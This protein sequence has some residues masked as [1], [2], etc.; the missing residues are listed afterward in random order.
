MPPSPAL[1]LTRQ[2][3][4]IQSLRQPACYAHPVG[5]VELIETHISFVLL[6]GDYVYKIKKEVNFGFLD[7]SSL[8]KRKQ[9]CEEELRLNRRQA[10]DLYLDV[11]AITGTPEHPVLG[12]HGAAFE[13][14]VKMRRFPQCALLDQR[15]ESG[16]LRAEHIDLLATT[17]VDFHQAVNQAE[18]SSAF[19]GLDQ[20]ASYTLENCR[21]IAPL[22][23]NDSDKERLAFYSDWVQR[24]H[25][26]HSALFLSRKQSGFIRECHGD[27]H[28][29]NIT[30]D[31][32][33]IHFFDCIEF[34]PAL[35]WI[36]VISELAFLAM[37]LEAAGQGHYSHRLINRY[38]ELT[39]D[40]T[41]VPLLRYY[42]AYRAMVRA[43]VAMLRLPQAS[44]EKER[45]T[46]TRSCSDYLHLAW[47][48][49]AEYS[50]ALIITHGLSG[51]GKSTHTTTLVEIIGAIRLR[52][53]VERKRL[54]GVAAAQSRQ[55]EV[56]TGI[57]SPDITRTLYARLQA[58]AD[59]ILTA[60]FP[61]IIDATCLKRWQRD[62][63]R[64][65]A[66]GKAVRYAL[67]DFPVDTQELER[68]ITQRQN[69][70]IDASDATLAV[71]HKQI[72]AQEPLDES[73]QADAFSMP[74]DTAEKVAPWQPL[75]RYLNA[76]DNAA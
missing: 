61:V 69:N 55:A 62:L 20:I 23:S 33:N 12:S 65:A 76:A 7:F 43:K 48:Y 50:P 5:Q 18:A 59:T 68:R 19:G 44:S 17:L 32:G 28:L 37:D 71:L 52:S 11:V 22:L 29:R 3:Q 41:G 53:D 46:L 75:L 24:Q 27:L 8:D 6:A 31:N 2:A 34:N 15:L 70:E 58:M 54:F 30:L 67:I 26:Q 1:A 25:Q 74:P 9:C 57:Y 51:S 39:G 36:D 72:A 35:R 42:L 10:A 63:F 13:Y 56:N 14:A 16:E 49:A 64:H 73:E 45:Q 47:R 40:Y 66:Q 38:F 60:G 4:L 21:V